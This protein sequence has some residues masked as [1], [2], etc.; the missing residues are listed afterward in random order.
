MIASLML[1][2][3]LAAMPASPAG[4]PPFTVTTQAGTAVAGAS[5]LAGDRHVLVYVAPGL[6]PAARLIDALRK[7]SQDDAR[8][9]TSVVV[10]VAAPVDRARSWL[11]ERWGDDELPNWVADANSQGW[12][13]LGFEGTVGVAG[14]ENG[15]VD[16]K[17]DGVIADPSVVEP[18]MRAWTGIGAP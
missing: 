5:L 4:P 8:W 3:V 9:R 1:S 10:V 16:W 2:L 15:T 11:R 13:A 7:W 18:S 14:V 12:R 17:L 6:E